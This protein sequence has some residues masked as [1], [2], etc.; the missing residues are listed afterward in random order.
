MRQG[1]ADRRDRRRRSYWDVTLAMNKL[2]PR[3]ISVEPVIHGVLKLVWS[4]GYEGVVDL[5][6][7]IAEGEIFEFVRK[8]EN[9]AKVSLAEY[10]HSIHWFDDNGYEIDLGSDSLREDAEKQAALLWAAAS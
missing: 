7:A 3:I 9:F 2:L 6:S 8:P 1:N 10:G 5:R 4:D